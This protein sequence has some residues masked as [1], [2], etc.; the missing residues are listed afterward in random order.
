M[1]GRRTEQ[2]GEGLEGALKGPCRPSEEAKTGLRVCTGCLPRAQLRGHTRLGLSF[3]KFG[4]WEAA[5]E[6]WGPWK[7]SILWVQACLPAAET[8]RRPYLVLFK[9]K[10]NQETTALHYKART[11]QK[12]F[13][14]EVGVTGIILP[15]K[16]VLCNRLLEAQV[17]SCLTFLRSFRVSRVS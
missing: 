9:H 14:L 4:S 5:R 1:A 3:L 10:K 15:V 7:C 17:P 13:A 6:L 11:T 2:A 16:A 12:C 8:S